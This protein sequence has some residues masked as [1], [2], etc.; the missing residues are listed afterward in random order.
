MRNKAKRL[1]MSSI[2]RGIKSKG[3]NFLKGSNPT[4][5]L[6][7]QGGE[8]ARQLYANE[9]WEQRSQT[10]LVEDDGDVLPMV[11]IG[12]YTLVMLLLKRVRA[13]A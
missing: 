11:F 13:C 12:S 10:S 9:S 8:I 7:G 5:E 2:H 3:L 4:N 1:L 6:G